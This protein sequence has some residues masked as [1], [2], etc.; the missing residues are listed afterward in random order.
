M[1]A[2][3]LTLVFILSVTATAQARLGE[4]ADQLVARYGQPLKE[5]DQKSEGVKVA[6]A[7]VNFQKG[8]FQITVTLVDGVSAA[9]LFKKINGAVLS[10]GEVQTLLNANAGGHEW[11]AP[12]SVQGEKI[13]LRDDSATAKLSQDGGDLLIKSKELISAQAAAKKAESTPTLDGF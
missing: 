12:Q 3:L 7:D 6:S 8:G 4:N 1:R 11:E 5:T 9:E 13:W 10:T 2:A